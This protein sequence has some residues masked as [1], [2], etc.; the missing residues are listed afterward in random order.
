MPAILNRNK[1]KFIDGKFNN[2]I[3]RN[4]G[5]HFNDK[6]CVPFR[7]KIIKIKEIYIKVTMK[8]K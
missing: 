7:Y 2:N 1:N 4:S 8:V 6:S 5:Y 3:K